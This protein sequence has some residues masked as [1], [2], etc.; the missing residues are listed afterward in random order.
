MFWIA[1]FSISALFTPVATTVGF[2]WESPIVMN[3]DTDGGLSVIGNYVFYLGFVF[4]FSLAFY[5]L[6]LKR[7]DNSK[8]QEDS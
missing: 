5:H 6:V 3:Y 7:L 2:A 8:D 1:W 4:V